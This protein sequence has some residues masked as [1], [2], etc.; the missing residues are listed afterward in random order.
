MDQVEF[1]R[2]VLG[3]DADVR[4]ARQVL[5]DQGSHG[6]HAEFDAA[7][8]AQ[9]AARGV[10]DLLGDADGV[11]DGGED[12]DGA[13]VDRLA[14]FGDGLA[15]GG[16]FEQGDA[17]FGFELGDDAADAGALDVQ[18]FGG[19]GEA[20]GVDD[21]HEDGE[22]FQRHG[23]LV[24]DL[25]RMMSMRRYLSA[26]GR[27]R[28]S[29]SPALAVR[30]AGAGCRSHSAMEVCRDALEED[31][32]GWAGGDCG[33]A[34]GGGAGGDAAFDGGLSGAGGG[35]PEWIGNSVHA[36][37]GDGGRWELLAGL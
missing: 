8:D 24:S 32:V 28:C 5:L 9:A 15:A 36:V 13:L 2:G 37:S 18:Q 21:F 34:G 12:A 19:A 17:Q 30:M 31:R 7:G 22:L 11:F 35:G 10:L 20:A 3:V 26:V 16:A 23:T 6:D 29:A 4:V 33:R 14:D 27:G 1:A 25:R